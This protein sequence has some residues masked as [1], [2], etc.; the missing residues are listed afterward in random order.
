VNSSNDWRDI[1]R[2]IVHKSTVAEAL[3]RYGTEQ[4]PFNYR[5]QH[6]LAVQAVAMKLAEL[7]GAD[8]EVV[9]AAA[10]LHDIVKNSS[11]HHAEDGAD[12]ARVVLAETDF[13]PEKINAVAV[14]IGNHRSLWRDEPLDDLESQVLWD[15]DKLAKLGLTAAFQWTG[16]LLSSES[17]VDGRDVISRMRVDW[18][19]K[20]VASMHT[21]PARRAAARRLNAYRQ[22]WDGLESE[23]SGD[24]LTEL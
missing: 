11:K 15:A 13:P 24:D 12:R 8:A 18:Q 16:M 22:F 23:L 19:E 20:T 7:T 6:I 10:W 4:P 21:G 2:S 9:E 17:D 14:A 3:N 1:A 5:W